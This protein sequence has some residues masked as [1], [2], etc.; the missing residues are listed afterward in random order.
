MRAGGRGRLSTATLI[1]AWT[2]VQTKVEKEFG[3]MHC[4]TLGTLTQTARASQ[5]TS[6]GKRQVQANLA[7]RAVLLLLPVVASYVIS[8]SLSS[9]L[10]AAAAV[11]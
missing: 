7:F 11:N 10:A 3:S 6:G 2:C 5:I 4:P 9:E 8:T 1:P